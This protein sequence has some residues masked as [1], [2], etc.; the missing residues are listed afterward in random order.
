MNN[1]AVV[2][3]IDV[4]K[5]YRTGEMEVRAVR[6]VSKGAEPLWSR[7]WGYWAYVQMQTPAIP[8]VDSGATS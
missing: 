3:L 7:F 8:I 6:G 5:T 2:K 4:H 1:G